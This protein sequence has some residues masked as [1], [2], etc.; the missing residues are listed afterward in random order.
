MKEKKDKRFT[1]P[2][3]QSL[4]SQ[5]APREQPKQ[6]PA[7]RF[8]PVYSAVPS[9]QKIA[10]TPPAI[11]QSPACSPSPDLPPETP[12]S[13]PRPSYPAPAPSTK[14]GSYP[15][16]SSPASSYLHTPRASP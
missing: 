2:S 3:P 13:S 5:P 11:Q 8:G 6:R 1:C 10:Y 15:T 9:F 4:Q 12:S 7:S 16:R 14:P